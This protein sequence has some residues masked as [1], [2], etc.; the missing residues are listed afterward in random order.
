[1]LSDFTAREPLVLVGCGNMGAAMATRWLD[2][3]LDPA[4]FHVI[5][6]VAKAALDGADPGHFHESPD[7][8]PGS[9]HPRMIVVAV[10]PQIIADVLAALE[11]VLAA[12][13][14]VVSVA[15]GTA[16]DSLQR[17]L[18]GHRC[19]VRAMPNTP[20]A[21]GAGVTLLYAGSGVE[22]L[23]RVLAGQ[24]MSAVGRVFWMK[25]E[26]QLDAGTA[27]SGCGPAYC[28]HMVEAMAAAAR[29]LGLEPDMAE[30]MAR[31]TLI[32]AGALLASRTDVSAA[33]LRQQVT[34][35]NGVT[36]A[37]LEEL[38]DGGELVSLMKRTA[39]AALKRART[40]AGR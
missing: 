18:G 21:V 7:R 28:F 31:H 27:I 10:K 16:M 36:A 38:K 32:G 6:P 14:L 37:G 8:L 25:S 39:R 15:A 30:D 9:V 26:D 40:L 35:P 23:D 3:G 29:D 17:G 20:A 2:R 13:T 34:S 33:D 4:A 22:E 19:I 24:C 5:D 1:M 11:P 12:D